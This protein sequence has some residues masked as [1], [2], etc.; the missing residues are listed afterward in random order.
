MLFT[1]E[2]VVTDLEGTDLLIDRAERVERVV[3]AEGTG[4]H[5]VDA[6]P[7]AVALDVLVRAYRASR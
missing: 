1:P 4:A 3:T 5:R 6:P 2:E 7:H